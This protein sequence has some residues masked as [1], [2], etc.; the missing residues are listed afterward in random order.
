MGYYFDSGACDDCSLIRNCRFCS[1]SSTCEHCEVGF[2][3]TGLTG[4]DSCSVCE[5]GCTACEDSLTC[6]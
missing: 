4:N 3:A 6:L 2:Y 5:D 1:D